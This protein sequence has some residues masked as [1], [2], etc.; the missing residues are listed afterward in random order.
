MKTYIHQ[1]DIDMH[2]I[3]LYKLTLVH[4]SE[5]IYTSRVT[6]ESRKNKQMLVSLLI[7]V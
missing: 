5:T 3:I 2:W 1:W 4:Y 7:N 6:N